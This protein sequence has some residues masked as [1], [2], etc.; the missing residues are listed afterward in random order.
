[1]AKSRG[2]HAAVLLPKD[3]VLVVGGLNFDEDTAPEHGLATTEI[4][5][6]KT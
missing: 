5:H 4:Y 6:Q 1:M 3:R 2:G